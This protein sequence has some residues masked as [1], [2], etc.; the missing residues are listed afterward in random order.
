MN[1]SEVI[2]QFEK[3]KKKHGDINVHVNAD[4]GQELMACTHICEAYIDSEREHMPE[5]SD[6][7]TEDCKIVVAEIQGY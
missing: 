3:L 6:T 5:Y 1:I 4:H 2:E 7:E